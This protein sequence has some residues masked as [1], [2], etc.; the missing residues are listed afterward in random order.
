MSANDNKLNNHH[1]EAIQAFSP[2]EFGRSLNGF[3]VNILTPQV[4]PYVEKLVFVL[5][6]TLVRQEEAFAVVSWVDEAETTMDTIIQIHADFTYAQNPYYEF[7]TQTDM[8]GRGIEMRIYHIDPDEAVKR[9]L[10]TDGWTVVQDATDKPHGLREAFLLD[11]LG[12]CW[13]PSVRSE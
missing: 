12:Y 10:S 1:A 5:G 3:G 9:A 11:D 8:R 4:I 13:V 7:L 6:L 2:P